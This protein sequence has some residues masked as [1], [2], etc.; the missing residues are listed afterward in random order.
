MVLCLNVY[1][2]NTRGKPENY[3]LA[4]ELMLTVIISIGSSSS[5]LI[6]PS[7]QCIASSPW[8]WATYPFNTSLSWL[9]AMMYC[10]MLLTYSAVIYTNRN[11]L[12]CT[13]CCVLIKMYKLELDVQET[14]KQSTNQTDV[15]PSSRNWKMLGFGFP[16]WCIFVHS[17]LWNHLVLINLQILPVCKDRLFFPCS[18][19]PTSCP[20]RR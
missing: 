13:F 15:Q 19:C 10:H 1:S 7:F 5:L 14:S 16:G 3:S 20:A 17:I 4:T 8:T 9:L 18:P 2:C 12:P 11:C 6:Y